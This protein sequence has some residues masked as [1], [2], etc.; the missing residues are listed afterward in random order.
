[1]Y[2]I[3]YTFHVLYN[4]KSRLLSQ[5]RCY[6]IIIL[7][8]LKIF[9]FCAHKYCEE[10]IVLHIL[11]E[12]LHQISRWVRFVVTVP[13]WCVKQATWH[14]ILS[15]LLPFYPWLQGCLPLAS[16]FRMRSCSVLS[17]SIHKC[18][19]SQQAGDKDMMLKET[20]SCHLSYLQK[21][22]GSSV[23]CCGTTYLP[24]RSLT[25]I[26]PKTHI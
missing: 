26:K 20:W 17:L 13:I 3:F 4:N 11:W 2:V 24:L 18:I 9:A 15:V 23:P 8:Q 5:I 22:G 12:K 25:S 14:Q 7:I 21:A 19:K 10:N 16:L 1:M 6:G